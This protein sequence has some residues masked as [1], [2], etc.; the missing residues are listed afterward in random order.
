MMHALSYDWRVIELFR[1]RVVDHMRHH[2]ENNR[3]LP[4]CAHDKVLS[5]A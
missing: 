2:S 5:P 1:R 3:L 4:I